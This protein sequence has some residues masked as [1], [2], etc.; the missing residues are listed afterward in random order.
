MALTIYGSPRS[1]TMRTLWIAA[2][3]GL[4][5][6]HV[7]LTWD[8][9]QLK[10]PEFLALNPAGTIPT[11]VDNGFALGESLAINLYLAKKYGASGEAPLYPPAPEREAEV[12]R[13]TL[14]AQ[15]YLEPWVQRDAS[16]TDVRTAIGGRS[17][18][19]VAKALA[20]VDSALGSRSWLVD[21]HFTVA[22]LNVACV[23][24]PS[25]AANIDM[26]SFQNVAAWHR[27]CY[28]RPAAVAVRR[29]YA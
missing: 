14:W 26:R 21:E 8:D 9:P 15:G 6:T 19:V 24:S 5:Y 22:D 2:E 16:L 3:L 1:R 23:L 12:W 27:R 28:E 4:D 29:R 7:P 10:T 18:A 20:T 13:W 17:E 25:R 11:I